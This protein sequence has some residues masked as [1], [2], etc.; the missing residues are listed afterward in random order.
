MAS[1]LPVSHFPFPYIQRL[2]A[3]STFAIR[4]RTFRSLSEVTGHDVTLD[5]VIGRQSSYTVNLNTFSWYSSELHSA[6][7]RLVV[8]VVLSSSD[9]QI[10]ITI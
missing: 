10:Q 6:R 2:S 4:A 8:P 9:G 7:S 5:D 1:Q 3:L